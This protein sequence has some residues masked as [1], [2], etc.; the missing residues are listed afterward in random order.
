MVSTDDVQLADV[1]VEMVQHLIHCH[2][3]RAFGTRLLGIV[4][5]LAGQD[6]DVRRVEV[7]IQDEVDLVVGEL[8]LLEVSH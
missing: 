8:T 3:V 4:A 2:L 5:E 6:A 1:A 7:A